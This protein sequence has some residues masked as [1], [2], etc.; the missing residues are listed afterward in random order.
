MKTY[1]V[2]LPRDVWVSVYD[3]LP[4]A[5][6]FVNVEQWKFRH[7]WMYAPDGAVVVFA[8]VGS[9]QKLHNAQLTGF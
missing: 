6:R 7:F 1:V 5:T 2:E 8:P 9:V 3:N 4:S